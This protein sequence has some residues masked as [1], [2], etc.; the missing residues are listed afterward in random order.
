L[1]VLDG[2][3]YQGGMEDIN[4]NDIETIDVLKDAS[5]AAVYG[6]RSSNGVIIITTK[7]GKQGKPM[8]NLNSSFGAA[9]MAT[10]QDVHDPYDFVNWRTD[11]MKSLNYKIIQVRRSHKIAFR[12]DRKYVEGWFDR[13]TA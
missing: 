3:I 8:I 7:K 12:C 2:V 9:T 5:S 6:A 10:L 4:P 13:R 1:V 11:V